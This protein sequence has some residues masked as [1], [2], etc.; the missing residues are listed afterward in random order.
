MDLETEDSALRRIVYLYRK[1]LLP[2]TDG[3]VKILGVVTKLIQTRV[4]RYKTWLISNSADLIPFLAKKTV[5]FLLVQFG[6]KTVENIKIP[7]LVIENGAS[8]S[9]TELTNRIGHIQE[10][11][12]E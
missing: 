8:P 12:S 1:R 3:D 4:P 2:S 7:K 11:S 9:L 5:G 6:L 10:L